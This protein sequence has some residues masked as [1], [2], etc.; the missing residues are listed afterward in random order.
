M[1]DVLGLAQKDKDAIGECYQALQK[2]YG[3]VMDNDLKETLANRITE[4]Q[5]LSD[6]HTVSIKNVFRINE[7]GRE[8]YILSIYLTEAHGNDNFIVL[9][10]GMM[11]FKNNHEPVLIQPETAWDRLTNLFGIG[12]SKVIEFIGAKN[13][14]RISL[15]GKKPVSHNLS[16]EFMDELYRTEKVYA[17]FYEKTFLATFNKPIRVEDTM[18]LADFLS[19]IGP[20]LG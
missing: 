15:K 16:K 6:Y 4:L 14:Y 19:R 5:L 11:V 9:M 3:C 20:A 12:K 18:R 2:K 7:N 13:K 1:L 17:E 8:F 10:F